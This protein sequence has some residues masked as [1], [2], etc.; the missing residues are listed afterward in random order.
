[1]TEPPVPLLVEGVLDAPS[2]EQ[3]FADLAAHAEILSI[4][5][6]GDPRGYAGVDGLTLGQARE[7]LLGGVAG[8]VQVRYRFEGHEWADTI[9]GS[10]AGFRVVR[11]QVPGEAS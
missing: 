8:R 11:C 6:K 5:E 9:L 7:R 4:H 2:L 1:M 10:P 3:L